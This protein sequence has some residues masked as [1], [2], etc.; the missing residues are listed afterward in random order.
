MKIF[1]ALLLLTGVCFAEEHPDK[2]GI[3]YKSQ[4]V[5]EYKAKWGS[6]IVTCEVTNYGRIYSCI[7]VKACAPKGSNPCGC[8]EAICQ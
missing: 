5:I 1:I 3:P 2:F 6:G 8:V 7:L 4:D